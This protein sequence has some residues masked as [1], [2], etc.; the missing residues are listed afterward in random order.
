AKRPD[1]IHFLF[2][3]FVM[4]QDELLENVSEKSVK[5]NLALIQEGI[6]K[7][8]LKKEY[9][10]VYSAEFPFINP[11]TVEECIETTN[12]IILKLP[13]LILTLALKCNEF[14]PEEDTY[15]PHLMLACDLMIQ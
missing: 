12:K 9:N 6:E 5:E 14:P 4:N 1:N 13:I 8:Q 15:V 2:H 7:F 10:T 11:Y 3:Q